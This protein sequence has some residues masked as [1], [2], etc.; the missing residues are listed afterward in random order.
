MPLKPTLQ[1]NPPPGQWKDQ[2]PVWW[3]WL[4]DVRKLLTGVEGRQNFINTL[5]AA[6]SNNQKVRNFFVNYENGDAKFTNPRIDPYL[7]PSGSLAVPVSIVTTAIT[8]GTRSITNIGAVR[9]FQT[10]AQA[11]T[12]AVALQLVFDVVDFDEDSAYVAATGVWT[13]KQ[14]GKYQVNLCAG[15]DTAVVVA[16]KRIYSSILK[17]GNSVS[18]SHAHTSVAQHITAQCGVLLLMNGTT[19]SCTFTVFQNFG[20]GSNTAATVDTCYFTAAKVD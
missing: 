20:A 9:A 8:S 16:P 10:V 2:P 11:T 18:I 14:A 17:N 4:D 7:L 5:V 1:A 12:S 19:D 13:P 3:K 6:V 15:F